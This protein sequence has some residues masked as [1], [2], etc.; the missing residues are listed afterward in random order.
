MKKIKTL[1]YE[2]QKKLFDR[3]SIYTLDSIGVLYEIQGKE[4]PNSFDRIFDKKYEESRDD[5]EGMNEYPY[6][7]VYENFNLEEI[8]SNFNDLSDLEL[9]YI[10]K[11]VL[12]TINIIKPDDKEFKIVPKLAEYEKSYADELVKRMT[13]IANSMIPETIEKFFRKYSITELKAFNSILKYSSLEGID[14]IKRIKSEV[15]NSKLKSYKNN[16]VST[17]TEIPELEVTRIAVED[18]YLDD[19]EIEFFRT[20]IEDAL[21]YLDCFTQFEDYYKTVVENFDINNYPVNEVRTLLNQVIKDQEYK[22]LL[23]AP[24]N[25]KTM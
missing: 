24:E 20:L 23:K 22:A 7:S 13:P 12:E 14:T 19:R 16:P 4:T 25:K 11:L 3:F 21:I 10:S 17:L 8:I 5:F 2:E 1:D 6:C 15:L 9:E 18:A